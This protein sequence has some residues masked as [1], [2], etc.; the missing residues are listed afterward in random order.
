MA[1]FVC[2][3]G[4]PPG[5]EETAGNLF[6]HNAFR[7]P[8]NMATWPNGQIVPGTPPMPAEMSS[9]MRTGKRL[10]GGGV[11]QPASGHGFAMHA[12]QSPGIGCSFPMAL[13]A[14]RRHCKASLVVGV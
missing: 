8:T 12:A 7:Q 5:A 1:K 2:V 6:L 9:R 10:P 11:I 14:K 3:G 13:H 4:T